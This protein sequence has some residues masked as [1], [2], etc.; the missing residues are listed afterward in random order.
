MCD[1]FVIVVTLDETEPE[2]ASLLAQ[3]SWAG[4]P[5]STEP[6]LL[7]PVEVHPVGVPDTLAA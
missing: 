2:D 7:F 1:T 6:V 5:V 3:A 4:L